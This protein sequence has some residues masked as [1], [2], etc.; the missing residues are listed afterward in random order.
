MTFSLPSTSCFRTLPYETFT[1]SLGRKTAPKSEP[2][3]QRDHF[4]SFNQAN[5]SFE[6]L[7]LLPTSFLKR[8]LFTLAIWPIGVFHLPSDA[9]PEIFSKLNLSFIRRIK[10]AEAHVS[11]KLNGE[12]EDLVLI[13][14]LRWKDTLHVML[15]HSNDL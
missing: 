9:A 15:Y 8:P 13:L 12:Q 11:V 1:S 14:G 10:Y 5:H 2:H 6:A 3:L 7:L 4:S